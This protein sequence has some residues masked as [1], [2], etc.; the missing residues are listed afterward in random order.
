MHDRMQKGVPLQVAL[1]RGERAVGVTTG[2]ESE[3]FRKHRLT[4]TVV[5][6]LR[7]LPIYAL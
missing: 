4:P 6:D 3:S 1:F 7:L 2:R 5:P